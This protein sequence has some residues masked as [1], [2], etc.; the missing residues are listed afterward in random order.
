[1]PGII[2][3]GVATEYVSA[4]DRGLHYGDG[5][6]ETI[7]CVDQRLQF[8]Q[9]HM[10][11]MSLAA[12]KLGL[13]FPGEQNF[14]DDIQQLLSAENTAANCVI[15]LMLTRGNSDRGYRVTDASRVCRIAMLT[16]WPVHIE[17]IRQQGARVRLCQTQVAMQPQ[18]ADIKH[19]SRIENVMARK[20][21]Q[22]EFDEGLMP[23]FHNHIIE[24][25]MS[26]LFAVRDGV[27][28]TPSLESCGINGI[29][30]QQMISIV[31]A[32][33]LELQETHMN[34]ADLLAMD[35]LMLTNSL[36]GIW[37]V[38]E[39]AGK[40]YSPANMTQQLGEALHRR[41]IEHGQVA[42]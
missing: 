10:A 25:T 2:I 9:Q 22:D 23:D 33:G 15:K 18:L 29:I 6:F 16:D 7:A 24:G 3:N 19:L 11:R 1:M 5:I 39:F 34:Q 8:W 40:T 20:E 12:E 30:R 27:L 28:Y 26:N 21:W 17:D 41:M 32:L 14:L 31:S 37:P 13:I 35:E 42:H 36:I 38:R 4:K